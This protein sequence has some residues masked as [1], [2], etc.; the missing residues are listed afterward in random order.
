MW[1]VQFHPERS[2]EEGNK[3][4]DAKKQK[5]PGVRILGREMAANVFTVKIAQEIF[6]NFM[7]ELWR[8]KGAA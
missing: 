6:T 2:L 4:L 1:G 3:S 7:K 8:S 5:E